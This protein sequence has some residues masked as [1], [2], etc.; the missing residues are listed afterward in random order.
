MYTPSELILIKAAVLLVGSFAAMFKMQYQA[1]MY[2]FVGTMYANTI[3]DFGVL[4]VILL[5]SY[6][7]GH[8]VRLARAFGAAS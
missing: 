5:A 2:V 8:L 6:V 3:G 7:M 1:L 4:T